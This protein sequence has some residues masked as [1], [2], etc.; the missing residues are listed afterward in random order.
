MKIVL[1]ISM[2]RFTNSVRP[3]LTVPKM[4]V[5]LT[6]SVTWVG[7]VGVDNCFN[8]LRIFRRGF[9]GVNLSVEAGV[10]PGEKTAGQKYGEC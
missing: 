4:L 1:A 7:W 5:K 10:M 8:G 9:N 3:Y 2:W 6:S